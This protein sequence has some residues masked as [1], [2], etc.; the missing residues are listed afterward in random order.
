MFQFPRR[1]VFYQ[2]FVFQIGHRKSRERKNENP[3]KSLKN[4]KYA[5]T[6]EDE[7][8]DNAWNAAGLIISGEP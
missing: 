1:F 4:P 8:F 6:I 2:L 3:G 5:K 7:F